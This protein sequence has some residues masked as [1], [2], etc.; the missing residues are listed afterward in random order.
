[1]KFFFPSNKKNTAIPAEQQRELPSLRDGEFLEG[2]IA[3]LP[4]KCKREFTSRAAYI[5]SKLFPR[6]SAGTAEKNIFLTIRRATKVPGKNIFTIL[7]ICTLSSFV[8]GCST[9]KS[10]QGSI[11]G[12]GMD[13]TPKPISLVGFKSS[14]AAHRQWSTSAGG[15]FGND[16]LKLTPVID[17]EIF[18]ANPHGVVSDFNVT[19]G[20]IIWLANANGRITSGPALGNGIVVVATSDGHVIA[21]NKKTG[22]LVWRT[23][24]SNGVFATPR[25]G[26]GLVLVKT[27]DDKLCALSVQSGKQEWVY[28]HGAPLLTLRT[29]SMPQIV[30]NKVI[31]GFADG[32]LAAINLRKGNLIWE[33]TVAPGYGST[34]VQ[35]MVGL[36]TDPIISNGVIYAA[37][38]QGKIAAV[39][40]AGGNILWENTISTYTDLALSPRFLFVTDAKGGIW[41]FNRMNGRVMW[42]Q[43]QLANRMLSS[44]ALMNDDVVV[45]DKEGHLYWLSQQDGKLLGDQLISK[46]VAINTTPVVLGNTVYVLSQNGNLSC[47]GVRSQ[48]LG[49]RSQKK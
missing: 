36:V 15:S 38:Y 34:E 28:D 33:Q 14:I 42:H 48:V 49:V 25:I 21:F 6:C 2:R 3:I 12:I 10:V 26:G 19:T 13:N 7:F 8:I 44:P 18:T 11:T 5:N 20:Q 4:S 32:K 31:V 22:R 17:G 27:V 37:T 1:M 46:N 16:Y 39:S 30:G 41:A 47:W 29:S 35:R 9:F 24:V 40:L 23:T 45:G 43:T